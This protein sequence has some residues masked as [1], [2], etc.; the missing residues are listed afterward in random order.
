MEE[1]MHHALTTKTTL[2]ISLA[3]T[4][5]TLMTLAPAA[6]ADHGHGR[7]HAYGH[8]RYYPVAC[9]P[10]PVYYAAPA[11]APRYVV[12]RPARVLVVRPAPYVQVGTRIGPVDISAIFGSHQRY[13]YGCNFCD[14]H[15]STF[16]AYE[17]HVEHCGYAPSNVHIQVQAWGDNGYGQ[18]AYDGR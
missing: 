9:A 13:E 5:A 15:F 14:A 1:P 10:Q 11:C 3:A 18:V 17:D 6:F 7:G 4:A 12:Y 8:R 16:G 2:A